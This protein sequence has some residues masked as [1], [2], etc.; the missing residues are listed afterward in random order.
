MFVLIWYQNKV[1]YD[2]IYGMI[3][4]LMNENWLVLFMVAKKNMKWKQESSTME[5]IWSKYLRFL[6]ERKLDAFLIA[7]KVKFQ[8]E[9]LNH[10]AT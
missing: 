6:D 7:E 2:T 9:Y 4:E 10:K 3:C 8:S 5:M 1:W